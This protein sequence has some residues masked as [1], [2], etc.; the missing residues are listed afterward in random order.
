MVCLGLAAIAIF[1]NPKI[2][3]KKEYYTKEDEENDCW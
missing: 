1:V 3:K 2:T